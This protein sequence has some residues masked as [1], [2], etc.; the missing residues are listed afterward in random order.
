MNTRT[1]WTCRGTATMKIGDVPDGVLRRALLARALIR[2]AHAVLLDNPTGDLD[3]VSVRLLKKA[4]AR[5]VIEGS[6]IAV[7]SSVDINFI[8]DVADRVLVMDGGRI[9]ESGPVD[10][11]DAELIRRYF[12]VDVI[13]SRNIYNGRPQIHT[14]PDA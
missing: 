9:V 13:I 10:I 2:S 8:A 3:I 1:S 4:L 6:R 7:I 14:F 11:I 12:G 5:Y